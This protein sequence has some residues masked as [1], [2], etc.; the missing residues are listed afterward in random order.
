MNKEFMNLESARMVNGGMLLLTITS[1]VS[2]M[3]ARYSPE[4]MV[5]NFGFYSLKK[6]MPNYT[7]AIKQSQVVCLSKQ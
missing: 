1:H 2:P 5:M 3:V 6:L 7:V 4:V